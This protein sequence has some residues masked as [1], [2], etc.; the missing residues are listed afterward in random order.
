MSSNIQPF[1]IT[2]VSNVVSFTVQCSKLNLFTNAV[3]RICS[4]DSNNIMV[5]CQP[6]TLTTEQYL[7]W[8][9]N[10]SYIINLVASTLGYTLESG[11]TPITDVTPITGV[12]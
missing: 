1:T 2:T 5:S 8:N 10:D 12:I 7:E 4:F 3:F 6:L 11:V 9:N